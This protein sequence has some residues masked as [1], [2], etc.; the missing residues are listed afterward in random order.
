MIKR[1]RILFV[2]V[3]LAA[4]S[5]AA[6]ATAGARSSVA[7]S[8]GTATVNLA[9]TARGYILVSSTGFTLYEFTRDSG[10][11]NSCIEVS[12]CPHFWPAVPTT[13]APTAGPGVKASL[14]ST[15]TLPD[16]TSQVTYAGHPLYTFTGDS[17][18]GET[19]YVGARAFGGYWYALRRSGRAVR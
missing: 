7:H 6:V 1:T 18:P 11:K 17:G 4:V 10:D 5:C 16:G 15:I 14:L 19:D 3:L 2:G 13:G 8:A 9:K 12:G